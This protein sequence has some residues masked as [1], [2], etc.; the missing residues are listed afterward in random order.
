MRTLALLL[1]LFALSASACGTTYI[2]DSQ[3]PDTPENRA[4]WNRVV[5]YRK[6]VE[7]R[8]ADA[9]LAMVSRAYYENSE[10]TDDATDDYGYD[11][12]RDMVLADFKDNVLEVQ[13]RLLMRRIQVDDDRA[14]ADYEYYYNFKY[15]EGGVTAWKPKNDFNRLEFTKEN[16]VWMISGGL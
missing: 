8:N 1:A 12:L 10:T 4:V 7:T 14:Y 5:E 13:Y 2:A 15:V 11:E 6:A 9:L 16:G 3:I